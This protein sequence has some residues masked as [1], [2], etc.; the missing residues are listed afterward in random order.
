MRRLLTLV[1]TAGCISDPTDGRRQAAQAS[2]HYQRTI[3]FIFAPTS[4]GQD[5]FVRGGIDHAAY[6]GAHP[7]QS[8]TN[9]AATSPCAIPIRHRNLRNATTAPWKQGDDFLDWYGAEA[10][11][12][13]A[14]QGS[15]A[16]WTTDLWP[17]DFSQPAPTVAV[18]GYGLEPLNQYGA[19]YWMLDVDMDCSRAFAGG[20]GTP[21]FEIKTFVSGGPGWEPA[22]AQSGTPYATGNHFGKCGQ[23]NVFRR[24]DGS[25]AFSTD[26]S[27]AAAA[28]EALPALD[29]VGLSAVRSWAQS[30][31]QAA[32]AAYLGNRMPSSAFWANE[33][34]YSV[35]VDRFNDGNPANDQ[36]NLGAWQLAHQNTDQDG[37]PAYVHGGDLQGIIDRLDYLR[38]L[39][40]TAL[41]VTP[42]LKGN[43]DYH[44]YCTADFTA[45]D[46]N[47]GTGED[48]RRMVAQAHLRG[49]RVVL[50][51]V[52]NHMCDPNTSYAGAFD[53]GSYQSCVST[54]EWKHWNGGANVTGQRPLA[55]GDTFFP[56]FRSQDFFS[57]CGNHGTDYTGEGAPALF[58]DFSPEMFDFDTMNWDW[59]GL[60]TELHKYWIAYADV[61]GFRMD[62]AKHVTEDFIATFST[63][64]RAYA[65]S[66]GK[67][68]F[69]IVGEVASSTTQQAYRVGKMR[70]NWI[71][72]GD[73]SAVIPATLRAR[74]QNLRSTY[75]AHGRFNFPGLNAV[76]D[77]GHSGTARNALRHEAGPGGG[78][79]KTPLDIKQWF[80]DGSAIDDAQLSQAYAELQANQDTSTDF[81]TLL[82]WN[83]LEIHDWPR[84]ASGNRTMAE[85]EGALA[86]LLTTKGTPVLHY[87]VEQGFD[88]NCPAV[89]PAGVPDAGVRAGLQG[90]CGG[91]NDALARQDMFGTGPWRLQSV[92]PSID[93]WAW[94]GLGNRPV[95]AS[96]P[97]VDE[98]G[99]LFGWVRRLIDIRQH[100][101]ALRLG[102]I[103]FRA[104]DANWWGGLLAF[105]RIAY[106]EEILVLINASDNDLPV[107]SLIV[108]PSLNPNGRVLVNLLDS[109]QAAT[110]RSGGGS[111]QAFF[112]PGFTLGAN[113]AA[114]FVKS[115]NV[116]VD[117]GADHA[118]CKG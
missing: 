90:L 95:P 75:L 116:T 87:G 25:A 70:S 77:F 67:D 54:L 19:H 64:L 56:P 106:G 18:N 22:V 102:Q 7:G 48:L 97:F 14:V 21:W 34:V 17:P 83:V 15:P 12:A 32:Q 61:D 69:F 104:A 111:A 38:D 13:G 107:T 4:S 52:V 89:T 31:T 5:V 33:V 10:A 50:D 42:V 20:D 46:P 78:A 63:E 2:A 16:D 26:F 3:V 30:R 8:C 118:R 92:T 115:D 109:A 72:P 105:S 6:A 93:R 98:S 41:W 39:G 108:D 43:G 44:G 24:G 40:V 68:N 114:I 60:F 51:V 59:Q 11:Q 65:K 62:A 88:G 80:Y 36:A 53:Y 96:D 94:I 66:L 57:R 100:C 9:D 73:A 55:F 1:L 27:G 82:D 79:A 103:Y 110:V 37:L 84:F 117:A 71:D 28:V 91:W 86:Y 58:G 47:F 76:Y 49:I 99:E 29:R 23:I 74:L 45:V 101:G 112:A 113:R 81:N 35:V 85:L